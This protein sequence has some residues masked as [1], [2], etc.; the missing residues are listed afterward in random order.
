MY[1][2][3]Q[4]KTDHEATVFNDNILEKSEFGKLNTPSVPW[5]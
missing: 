1:S 3:C 2:A 4:Q 5:D